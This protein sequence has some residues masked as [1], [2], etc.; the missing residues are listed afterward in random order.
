MTCVPRLRVTA[1]PQAVN[2]IDRCLAELW[3]SHPQ[4]PPRIRFRLGIAINEI[5]ANIV[6]HATK[7]IGRTVDIQMWAVVRDSDIVVT[8]ADDGIP[9]P[10]GLITRVMPHELDESGR[11]IPLARAALRKLEYRRNNELNF[12]ILLSEPF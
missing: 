4:V 12:W 3:S 2:R 11:G 8:F 6:E 9:A 7:G 1:E 10:D 5:V